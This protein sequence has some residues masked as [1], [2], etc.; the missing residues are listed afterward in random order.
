MK[1]QR[2]QPRTK[3]HRTGKNERTNERHAFFDETLLLLLHL[4][5]ICEYELSSFILYSY[6]LF[7]VFI[8]LLDFIRSL[9]L[10][11]FHLIIACFVLTFLRA[12]ISFLILRCK[13]T[14]SVSIENRLELHGM[15]RAKRRRKIYDKIR[16]NIYLFGI[17][18]SESTSLSA[19]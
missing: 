9:A 11:Y 16:N 18:T 14:T 17:L 7:C 5:K 12:V 2:E 10:E 8:V 1:S 19:E 15:N 4:L 13:F 3:M 6:L